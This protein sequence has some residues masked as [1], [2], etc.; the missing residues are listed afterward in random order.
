MKSANHG[1]GKPAGRIGGIV[2]RALLIVIAVALPLSA[3]APG[4]LAV[5]ANLNTARANHAAATLPGGQALIVGG[6]DSSGGALTSAEVFSLSGNSSTTLPTG[7]AVG[8]SGLTAT[9]L[10]DNTVLLAGGLD[11]SGSPVAAAQLYDPALNAF[12]ALP[13]MNAARSHH[14][15]TLLANGAVLIAGGSDGAGQLASLEIFD[16]TTRTFSVVGNLQNARQDHTATLLTDGTVL[17]AA[18]A[19]S[20]GPLSS[21]EI[22]NTL[23][24]TVTPAGS[25]NQART[26]ATASMLY[27]F[28]STVLIEG[29]QGAGGVDLNTAEEYDPV[30]GTF[31][32]LT[33]RMNIA[34]S[35]HVGVTLPYNGKVLIAG[36]TSSG[37]PVAANELYDPVAGAFV[38]DESSSVARDEIAA[39]L[40]A[41][42]AVGQVLLS[43]GLDASG[44]PLTLTEMFAY[45]TIRTDK[46]DYPPGSPVT[47]YGA[48]WAPGEQ[49]TIQIQ[50]T[51]S[52]DTF[53]T[54]TADSS[55][56]FTDTSFGDHGQRRRREIPDD[57]DESNVG[58]DGT[59]QVHGQHHY[60]EHRGHPVKYQRQHWGA[61]RAVHG[62]A[63]FRQWQ[64]NRQSRAFE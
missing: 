42:P 2:L 57:S 60:H 41:I 39:N 5:Y 58:G 45:P 11:A 27:N 64:R 48:G 17:I 40:F 6:T 4:S 31:T 20:S 38:A 59:V 15:A 7:L 54:D 24:N 19:G 16:P 13:T 3:Q 44:N 62:Y 23:G 8:V 21:A 47:I 49:V 25:L 56:S 63:H 28:D 61:L 34:R 26:R 29:G 46:S 52:D 51:D 33:S 10:N 9:V 18:G 32:T 22:F 43:G 30:T 14:T 37:T 1:A 53:L 50:E 12:V 36:G 55:G 35:G